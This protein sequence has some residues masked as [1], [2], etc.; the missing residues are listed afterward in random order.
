MQILHG[1]WIPQ[2]TD[3]FV[4]SGAF[5]L[6]VETEQKS[7]RRTGHPRH[8]VKPD[9]VKLLGE[10]LAIHPAGYRKLENLVTRCFFLLPT[11]DGEPLPSLEM[12]RYLEVELPT[13]FDWQYW[14]IDC[15][16]MADLKG[17]IS[18]LNDL[19]FLGLHN[20]TE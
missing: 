7:R 20:L 2:T 11:V 1:T 8:L 14:A 17:L 3:D 19:H 16:R 13:A 18:G 6:W 12:A 10:E 15:Y 5:Y 4:Q 9:L